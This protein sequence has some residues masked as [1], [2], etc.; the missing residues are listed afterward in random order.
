MGRPPSSYQHLLTQLALFHHSPCLSCTLPGHSVRIS[1]SL[2]GILDQGISQ[3]NP[4]SWLYWKTLKTLKTP[5]P[6]FNLGWEEVIFSVSWLSRLPQSLSSPGS[7]SPGT[8][9]LSHGHC[10]FLRGERKGN[11]SLTPTSLNSEKWEMGSLFWGSS[12]YV[13]SM[14]YVLLPDFPQDWVCFG[15]TQSNQNRQHFTLDPF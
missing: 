8:Y 13:W 14:S 12:C 15:G 9:L 6:H 2:P 7:L 5:G 10:C 1:N 4:N 3:E 11:I